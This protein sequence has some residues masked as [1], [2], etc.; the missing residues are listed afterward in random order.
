MNLF[1]FLSNLETY[2]VADSHL[3]EPVD[4]INDI[5]D[6]IAASK[7]FDG[8]IWG[9]ITYNNDAPSFC[10]RE[11]INRRKFVYYNMNTNKPSAPGND[12]KI[13]ALCKS[14]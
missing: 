2:Y 14:K 1:D 3:C 7:N 12:E 9:G 11:V 4:M 8:F 10:Y 6:C 5:R 13:R